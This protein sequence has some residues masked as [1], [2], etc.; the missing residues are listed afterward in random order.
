MTLL[1]QER[2]PELW[3]RLG[4]HIVLTGTATF[5][6]MA[7]G[8]P[9]GILAARHR[10][11]ENGITG[12]ASILQT[13]PSLAMLA[14]LLAILNR[15]GFVPAITALTLYALLPVVRGTLTGFQSIPAA[16]IEAARGVG[17]NRRQQLWLV[18]LPLALPSIVTGIRTAAVIGVG[19]ATLSAFI[20]AGG[21][22]QFINRGL[23]LS[24]HQLILLGAVPSALLAL[25]IDSSIGAVHWAITPRVRRQSSSTVRVL[26]RVAL[27]LPIMIFVV[28]LV[29]TVPVDLTRGSETS[30]TA[31]NVIRIGAK[32]F[33]EQLILGELMAQLIERDTDLTVERT[34]DLGGTMICH[35]ALLAGEIDL[36][37]E[38]TG[39]GLTTILKQTE[40]ADR[41]GVFE[42]VASAYAERF[43]LRWLSPFGFNNT[44]AIAV[45]ESVA[46][47]R[48]WMAISDL[49]SASGELKAGWT[50]EFSERPDGYPGLKKHYSMDFGQLIDL[51]TSLMYQAIAQGEVGVICAFSTDGRIIEHNLRVLEDDKHFFPPYEA[52]PVVRLQTLLRHPG[53]EQIL[54]KLANQLDDESMRNL[55]GLVDIQKRSPKSV[56]SEFLEQVGR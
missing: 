5:L 15:I 40:V 26:R 56:A 54:T 7:L 43:D 37:A 30:S 31:Q 50:F 2:L 46:K 35:E 8:L 33:T 29:A 47:S 12:M 22:G 3:L 41:Q 48:G 32:N 49:A 42:A 39:T 11:L 9:L 17:M 55:N 13:I 44:Y 45:Q 28:G 4:E 16:T 19:I 20:G 1:L 34:F 52:A 18:E 21:L 6:A 25:L 24:N 14:F 53:L 38:Y 51:E 10:M 27:G 23:S 36:Y